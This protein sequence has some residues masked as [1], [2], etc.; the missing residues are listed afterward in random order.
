MEPHP[1]EVPAEP[2]RFNT[3][4]FRDRFIA[5]YEQT[6]QKQLMSSAAALA[7]FL[8]ASSIYFYRFWM[9]VFYYSFEYFHAVLGDD[10]ETDSCFLLRKEIRPFWNLSNRE[11]FRLQRCFGSETGFEV[12]GDFMSPL[13]ALLALVFK[14]L[15]L[16]PLFVSA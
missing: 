13:K 3:R 7:I 9:G 12:Q 6:S 4:W 16:S 8:L 14:P 5:R 10:Y 2:A 11:Y 15:F 1:P